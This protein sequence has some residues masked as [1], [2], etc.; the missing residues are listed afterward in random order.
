MQEKVCNKLEN[1]CKKL[2]NVCKKLE[3]VCKKLEKVHNQAFVYSLAFYTYFLYLI[4]F[5]NYC[6]FEI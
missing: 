4:P 1:V 2:E 6:K 5:D 3:N